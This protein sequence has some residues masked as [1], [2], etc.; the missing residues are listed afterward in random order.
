MA[1]T[2][3]SVL[4]ND[5]QENAVV[6]LKVVVDLLRTFKVELEEAAVQLV[7]CFVKLYSGL[8]DAFAF[9]FG[10]FS[11][12]SVTSQWDGE[13]TLDQ[14]PAKRS[15]R[16]VAECPISVLHLSQ[17]YG[18][19]IRHHVRP[20]LNLMVQLLG[21]KIPTEVPQT[22]AQVYRDMKFA[23][24]KTIAFMA[25]Y[26]RQAA[27]LVQPFEEAICDGLVNLLHTCPD[28]V[29]WRKELL[30]ATRAVLATD[31]K[32]GIN[33]RLDDLREEEA[34]V[35][36]SWECYEALRHYGYAVFAEIAHQT[37]RNLKISQLSWVVHRSCCIINDAARPPSS[38]STAVR[39]LGNLVEVIHQNRNDS[40]TAV[41]N[42]SRELLRK[43]LDSF[44]IK[45]NHIGQSGQLTS[46]VRNLL[47]NIFIG[48]RTVLYS[49]TAFTQS[50][51][52]NQATVSSTKPTLLEE[53]IRLAVRIIKG[54]IQCLRLCNKNGGIANT[55]DLFTEVFRLMHPKDFVELM[56]SRMDYLFDNLLAEPELMSFVAL[57]L[58]KK[59]DQAVDKK[60]ISIHFMEI[61]GS[62]LVE[63]KLHCLARPESKEAQLVQKMFKF[64]FQ[65][66]VHKDVSRM[67]G[68][69]EGKSFSFV[70]TLTSLVEKCLAL[71]EEKPNPLGYLQLL[72]YLFK[73]LHK[74]KLLFQELVPLM[75]PALTLFLSLLDGPD[76][77]VAKDVLVELCL[78]LPLELEKKY[79][80]LPKLMKPLVMAL[81]AE[82]TPG[83]QGFDDIV[84]LGIATM[85]EW[86]DRLNPEF[87]EPAMASVV[88]DLNLALWSH[89]RPSPYPL[90]LKV[91][92]LL[93]KLGGRNRRFL[94]EPLHLECKE[95]PELGLRFILTFQPEPKFLVPLDKC[96]ALAKKGLFSVAGNGS[97]Q[98]VSYYQQQALKFLI[99]CLAS[100]MNLRIQQDGQ[101]LNV[102]VAG[103]K[104]MIMEGPGTSQQDGSQSKEEHGAKTKSQLA[105]ER[106]VL[107]TLIS[108]VIGAIANEELRD[109][110]EPFAVGVCRHFAMLF[111]AG[112]GT[113]SPAT[114]PLR[115]AE[116]SRST[117]G[118]G[119]KD[120]DARLFLD[121][122][123]EVLSDANPRIAR[124]G[125][126]ALA[127][128]LKILLQLHRAKHKLS[129]GEDGVLSALEKGA[130]EDSQ[131]SST[132]SRVRQFVPIAKDLNL[133]LVLDDL[134]PR[135]IHCC[136]GDEWP[137]RIG[138]ILGVRAIIAELPPVYILCCGSQLVHALLNVLRCLPGFAVAQK[139]I[140]KE[141]LSHLIQRTLG[142]EQESGQAADAQ[143]LCEYKPVK[144]MISTLASLT[145]SKDTI[146][147]V[148]CQ[149]QVCIEQVAGALGRSIPELLDSS[150]RHVKMA[151]DEWRHTY[152]KA[153]H[154]RYLHMDGLSRLLAFA[155][156]LR[157]PSLAAADI[158]KDIIDYTQSVV[159]CE[160]GDEQNWQKYGIRHPGNQIKESSVGLLVAVTDWE[161]FIGHTDVP[162]KLPERILNLF[163]ANLILPSD[164]LRKLSKKGLGNMMRHG[165]IAHKELQACLKP[166]LSR[167]NQY[168]NLDLQLL[169]GAA[170]A[171]ELLSDWFNKALGEKLLD[172]LRKWLDPDSLMSTQRAWQPEDDPKIAA[173]LL[174]LF[175][176]LPSSASSFLETQKTGTDRIGLVVLTIELEGRL[177]R[178]QGTGPIPRV[179]WSPY[180]G[181][182]TKFLVKYAKASI[183][184]FLS[185]TRMQNSSYFLRFIDIIKSEVG[186]PLLEEVLRSGDKLVSV[187]RGEPLS[188]PHGGVSSMPSGAAANGRV[189]PMASV[190][191]LH[192][193]RTL[194]KQRPNW[195]AGQEA[196]FKQLKEM[197][198][199][200]LRLERMEREEDMNR[201]EAMESKVIA[202]CLLN[203][204]S[205]HHDEVATLVDILTIF[206]VKTSVDFS[207]LETFCS[208]VVAEEY[209][210]AERQA[211]LTY[212]IQEFA[213]GRLAAGLAVYTMRVLFRPILAKAIE[214]GEG[215]GVLTAAMV[216]DFVNEMKGKENEMK[217]QD[218]DVSLEVELLG[219]AKQILTGMPR[220]LDDHHRKELLKYAWNFLK[221]E[222]L[223]CKSHAFLLVA[224]ILSSCQFTDMIFLQVFVNLLKSDFTESK[225]HLVREALDVL[226]PALVERFQGQEDQDF[227]IWIRYAHKHMLA[228]GHKLNLLVN[229]WQ[230]V[231]RHPDLFYKFRAQFI[232]QMVQTLSRL[233][234][235]YNAS[236]ENRKMAIDM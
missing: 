207:F 90:G 43:I 13:Q 138:G 211:V 231:V 27:V 156:N 95:N 74:F 16:L 160:M 146:Q 226:V 152:N 115:G 137:Q 15:F 111:A 77:G 62:Y 14:Q 19:R 66:L 53:E 230:M 179:L 96:I 52:L 76:V 114:R 102:T 151:L 87:L 178:M 26:I 119:T 168:T 234:L 1:A 169:R 85:E 57:L 97:G 41:Q 173:A 220:L 135:I 98:N 233:R 163:F 172:H 50:G 75:Q 184:Y 216:K 113:P 174:E 33:A 208:R 165:P 11:S 71:V 217:T 59:A 42:K 171:L 149:A 189:P 219:A 229:L 192:L 130:L 187:L 21:K 197:W 215:D 232:G 161:A 235:P 56:S 154:Q 108:T 225:K 175:H 17:L 182:L 224:H 35:G 67:L 4:H 129:P 63:H 186:Q 198:Q 106:Q 143:R 195:L 124:T 93:G 214:K 185:P 148:R 157:L 2:L 36:R 132:H 29:I 6:A 201:I 73:L 78:L 222:N 218:R 20:L 141:T 134:L 39:L 140:I 181:P 194:V 94:K 158:L 117:H 30:I 107:V 128:F 28:V 167:I 72:L 5:S 40:D 193:L 180:R 166:I 9:Y 204:I 25:H 121:A 122:L 18:D 69:A 92:Q 126:I 150:V 191:S 80:V 212:V 196:L 51:A 170:D 203:Y 101:P 162:P 105:A 22:L 199:S 34:L 125:E 118:P 82:S 142:L 213:S 60:L 88:E 176:L 110:A 147:L 145:L 8:E 10:T 159:M 83:R 200:P 49:L 100:M 79:P 155:I 223:D 24:V 37:R 65:M 210:A 58:D 202:K 127:K 190:H 112:V 104:K 133:P 3:I 23:Q 84:A 81:K 12:E 236:T 183:N 206:T 46:E 153:R 103:L 177:G 31:F 32:K 228:E 47:Q 209:T 64:L 136:Y 164:N 70:S 86:V 45:L 139:N 7:E 91:L 48:L 44:V 120:L 188:D 116:N 68:D 99:V 38:H 89:L 61:L 54:G 123:V 109:I 221:S 144:D 227:P 131:S 55:V 205:H